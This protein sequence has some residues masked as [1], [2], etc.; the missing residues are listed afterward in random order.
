MKYLKSIIYLLVIIGLVSLFAWIFG[1]SSAPKYTINAD[2][3]A[4]IQQLKE[5]NKL[6]TASYQIEKVIDAGTNG[7]AFK[8]FF[9]GDRILLVANGSVIAGFDFSKLAANAV[10][11]EG[12]V[13]RIQLPPAEILSAALDNSKTRVYDRK[14]GILTSGNANLESQARAAAELSI[15][16]AA[17]DG[18]ILGKASDYAGKSLAHLFEAAG[19]TSV[20]V[21]IPEAGVCK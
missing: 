12:K 10:T 8:D 19:F 9:F 11:I 13:L 6:E 1:K 18:D 7:G 14:V 5:L 21:L 4:I 16:K 20:Q 2:S 17:C 3:Q 15:R